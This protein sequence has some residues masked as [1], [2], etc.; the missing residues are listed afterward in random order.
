MDENGNVCITDFGISK[1]LKE[2]DEK[3][4]SFVGCSDYLAPEILLK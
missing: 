3:A 4:K 1:I 2:K